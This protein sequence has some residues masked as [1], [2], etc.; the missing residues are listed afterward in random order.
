MTTKRSIFT[1]L[2]SC[3]FLTFMHGQSTITTSGGNGSG[4]GG[5]I[6]FTVGQIAYQIF[7]G[8]TGSVAHGVQQPYEIS[9]VTDIEGAL[10]I[11]LE[12]KVYP[13]P[14][15]DFLTLTIKDYDIQYLSYQLM[16]LNGNLIESKKVLSGEIVIGMR[17]L[18]SGTYFLWLTHNKKQIKTFKIIKR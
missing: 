9:V 17:S 10:G 6:S 5:N 14:T 15:N 1:L 13:N 4:S 16:G 11:S 8:S 3:L 7:P 12:C 18:P 2:M